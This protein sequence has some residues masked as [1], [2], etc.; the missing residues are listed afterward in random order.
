MRFACDVM[1]G[2][3]A[4]YL[5]I[6]GFDATYLGN[7]NILDRYSQEEDS[8]YFLTRRKKAL[9]YERTICIKAENVREQLGELKGL[10]KPFIDPD[11]VLTRCINCNVPLVDVEKETVE[12]RIPEFVFHT[13]NSFKLC[14]HC[15]RVYWAGT[16][17]EHMTELI[18]EV[19]T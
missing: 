8:R 18:E 11:K 5:R 4:K 14:P 17:T 16:H 12:H 7:V 1:L 15:E 10:I 3:L 2:K 13:Y 9:G 19:R 6:L